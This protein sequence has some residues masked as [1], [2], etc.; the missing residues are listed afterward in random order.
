MKIS[1]GSDHG[2][3]DLKEAIIRHLKEKGYE[4]LDEGTYDKNSVDYPLFG[5]KTALDVA[6]KRADFGIVCCTSAEGIMIA[7]NKVKGIRCG[8]GYC[9]EACAKMREHNDC[10]MIA[11]GQSYMEEKD[12]LRRVDIFLNTAFEGGRHARRV[13]QISEIENS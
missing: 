13:N 8:I 11:F 9:D 4:V 6:E 2:G 12:V 7:A 10:N 3:F 1:V 5:R